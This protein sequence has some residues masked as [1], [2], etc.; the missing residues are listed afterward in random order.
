MKD[1]YKTGDLK[2]ING[3]KKVT[4]VSELFKNW[5]TVPNLLSAIRIILVPV[6]AVLF[7]KG[8]VGW[9]V[10]MLFLSGASDFFDGKIARRFNQISELGKVLDPLADKLTQITIAIM[11][12]IFFASGEVRELQWFSWIF[13]LFLG[14]E[15]FMVLVSV[16]M[17]AIGF[18]PIAAEIYGKVATFVF[19]TVMIF[20]ICFGPGVGALSSW[21]TMPTLLLQVLVVLS[22]ILTFVA[23]FSYVPPTVRGYRELQAQKKNE[24]KKSDETSSLQ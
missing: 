11:L 2:N 15:A 20:I 23:L 24:E 12:Y 8:E 16:I 10:F 6:F 4:N 7:Y 9:A 17:L 5:K 3:V 1:L 18:R 19:Y 14:K 13:L 22:A 21:W